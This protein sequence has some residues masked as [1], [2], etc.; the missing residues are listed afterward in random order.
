MNGVFTISLDFELHWGGF[1]KWK[2]E[3]GHVHIPGTQAYFRSTRE[4]IPKML[5]LFADNG[6]HVTWAAVGMLLHRSKETLFQDAP[7]IEPSYR[8]KK[9]SPYEYIRTRGI[10]NDEDSDPFHYAASLVERILATPG[11]ELGSHTF[12]HYYCNED[13]QSLEQ[14]RADL[15]AAVRSANRFGKSLRSLVFPRN[16]FNEEYLRICFEEGF[17][18][19]RD[20]PRDWFWNIESTQAESSWKRFN[21]GADAYLP[22]GRKNSYSLDTVSVRA[23]L[24]VCLPASRLLRPYRPS[25]YFLNNWKIARVKREMEMAAREGQVYHLWWHPHNFGSYPAESLFGLQKILTHFDHCRKVYGMKSQSMG[26][27]AD[28]ILSNHGAPAIA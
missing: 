16:Q 1:D 21:R 17:T 11:Q 22:I 24:P 7:S 8:V 27:T 6:I 19:V 25:E 12:G 14:F 10:G 26:E 20:N 9:L 5:Q 2:L 15:K 3:P 18:A 13:G 23:G 4:T 28:Q